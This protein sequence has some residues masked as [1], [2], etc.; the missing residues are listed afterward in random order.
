MI[1]VLIVDDSITIR[2]MLTSVLQGDRDIK[3]A[4]AEDVIEAEQMLTTDHFDV[5]TL[6]QE[7]PGMRGLEFLKLLRERHDAPVVMLSSSTGR[8]MDFR[9]QALIAGAAGVFDKADAIRQSAELI[10]LVKDV[11]HRHAKIEAE[12]AAAI[13]DHVAQN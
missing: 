13:R 3:V 5:I 8:G 1:N 12:D 2:G 11:A 7:M 4:V 6:D 10:K 9:T